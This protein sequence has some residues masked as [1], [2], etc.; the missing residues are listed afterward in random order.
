MLWLGKPWYLRS[1]CDLP[2]FHGSE[3]D[4]LSLFLP[5]QN[6]TYK[7]DFHQ[8]SYLHQKKKSFPDFTLVGLSFKTLTNIFF[9][10]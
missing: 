7:I 4:I 1:P 2:S 9:P 10:P 8:L 3:L 5:L 6:F